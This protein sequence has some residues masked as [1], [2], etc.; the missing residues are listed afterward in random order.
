FGMN[1]YAVQLALAKGLDVNSPDPVGGT[2]VMSAAG[3]G[4]VASVKLLLEKGANVNIVS[5]DAGVQKVKNGVIQLGRF[6]PLLL[7]STYGPPELVEMLLKAR[8]KVNVTDARG[9]TPLHFA[10]TSD[11]Q[12]PE[13]IRML[14]AAGADPKS[15]MSDGGD[16][17]AWA[18]KFAVPESISQLPPLES[19][20]VETVSTHERNPSEAVRQSLGILTR[21]SIN[22]MGTG[23]CV[24]C[25]A[26]SIAGTALS[27]AK[28][29]GITVDDKAATELL[30]AAKGR[31][32]SM[33]DA[34]LLR[35][36]PPGGIDEEGYSALHLTTAGY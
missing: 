13:I 10:V 12:N 3:N 29:H 22:F 16:A 11:H 15:K 25:H 5:A 30:A 31:W 34:L 21:V 20:P 1:P 35:E 7:A 19:A 32:Q 18:A 27:V 24:A 2:P 8:A 23:G 9:M 17:S 33:S 4:D 28:A 36:D 14:L 26:Q 6:T